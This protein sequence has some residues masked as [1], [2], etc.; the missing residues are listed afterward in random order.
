MKKKHK[1]QISLA[2][3]V[4]VIIST[5]LGEQKK[6]REEGQKGR[7]VIDSVCSIHVYRA[8][9]FVPSAMFLPVMIPHEVHKREK[10]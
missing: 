7:E 9:T 6:K 10:Y 1:R 2:T 4:S 5:K 3:Q 8:L